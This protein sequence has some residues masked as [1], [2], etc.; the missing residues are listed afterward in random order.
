MLVV[1]IFSP[2][3]KQGRIEALTELA[4]AEQWADDALDDLVHSIA[5]DNE[6]DELNRLDR[7]E[8]QDE[9]IGSVEKNAAEINN[10]GHEAQISYLVESGVINDAICAEGRGTH[11]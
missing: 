2:V 3:N 4:K 7:A 1:G 11:V 6:R 5:Q 9:Q 10:G 8:D